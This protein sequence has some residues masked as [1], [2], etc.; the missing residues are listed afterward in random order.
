MMTFDWVC[1][2]LV[3]VM[4][5]ADHLMLGIPAE[6][7]SLLDTGFQLTLSHLIPLSVFGSVRSLDT[8]V[9]KNNLMSE[10]VLKVQ[11]KPTRWL[12]LC[13]L[14]LSEDGVLSNYLHILLQIE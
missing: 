13:I 2:I 5:L 3:L 7:Q 12:L 11:M 8:V 9:P 1:L 14:F 4:L 6:C 10:T